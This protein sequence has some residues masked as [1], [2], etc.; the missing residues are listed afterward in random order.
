[1]ALLWAATCYAQPLDR[2]DVVEALLK[3]SRCL[4]DVHFSVPQRLYRQYLRALSDPPEDRPPPVDTIGSRGIYRLSVSADG[5]VTLAVEVRLLVLAPSGRRSVPVL[6]AS[7]AWSD[8]RLAAVGKEPIPAALATI[9]G[10]LCHTPRTPG[11]HVI[12]ARTML[13]R[14]TRRS[15]SV[16]L[17]IIPTVRTEVVFDSQQVFHVTANSGPTALRGRSPKGTHGSLVLPPAGRLDIRFAPLV[18]RPERPARYQLRGQVAWN[19]GA[20]AQQVA[21]DLEIAILG[22]NTDRLEIVLPAAARRVRITGGDV[23]QV[24]VRHGAAVVFLR[25]SVGGRTRLKVSY[26]HELPAAGAAAA[27]A[28]PEIRGGHWAA[29]TLAVTNTVGG[30]ELL[31]RRLAGLK[32][33]AL[34]DIPRSLSAMLAGKAVLAYRITS[35]R[36]SMQLEV[37]DLGAFALRQ[38]IADTAHYRFV[39]RRHGTVLCRADY[40]VRNRNR[41]FLRL[42]LPPGATVL[43][44]RV[45]EKSRP[46]TALAGQPDTYLLPLERSTASVEGLVSFPVQVVY[47][48]RCD[49][50]GPAGSSQVGLPR[51]DVPIAYAWCEAQMP[52][53]IGPLQFAGVMQP[54]EQYSSETAIETMGYGRAVAAGPEAPPARPRSPR[55]RL[56]GLL[57]GRRAQPLPVTQPAAAPAPQLNR[58]MLARNYWRAG[59]DFYDKMQYE[60]ADKAL[61]NVIRLAPKSTEAANAKRLASNI[62]FLQGKLRPEGQAAR[63]AGAKVRQTVT[64]ANIDDL[65]RQ[66]RLLEE[67]LRAARKG[68]RRRAQEQLKAAEAL[69]DQLIARGISKK[70]QSARLREARGKLA[71]ARTKALAEAAAH[72]KRLKEL[73]KAGRHEEASAEAVKLLEAAGGGTGD[74]DADA[75]GAVKKELEELAVAAAIRKADRSRPSAALDTKTPSAGFSGKPPQ[76]KTITRVYDIRDLIVRVPTFT[77][78]GGRRMGDG[79]EDQ[80]ARK[81]IINRLTRQVRS[82]LVGTGRGGIVRVRQANG[83][84]VVEAPA[85]AQHGVK[86][87]VA[88]LRRARGPQVQK[89]AALA[90]Q[91]AKPSWGILDVRYSRIPWHQP[92]RYPRTWSEVTNGRK[93]ADDKALDFLGVGVKD[94]PQLSDKLRNFLAS[95]YSWQRSGGRSHDQRWLAEQLRLNREQKVSVASINVNADAAAAGALGIS[96]RIGNNRV[97]YAVIDE[98]QFRTLMELDR[99]RRR[100]RVAA[101]ERSQETIV[102][103]DA[104]LAN[105]AV[106]NVRYAADR[107]NILD[108]NDNPIRLSH[109]K[110]ILIDNDGYLT[111]VRAEQMQH[112]REAP[113]PV[114]FVQAPQ[115]IEI[116][117]VGQ[118]VKLEKTLVKPDDELAVRFTYRWKGSAE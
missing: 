103:T 50:L 64:A 90:L 12:S 89:G 74:F 22:R 58:I 21:A 54:V 81:K 100:G 118:L 108:I 68:E 107:G 99:R 80:K 113:A 62:G 78:G 60:Q 23:R 17:P 104:L 20:A 32:E 91:Q 86:E 92:L 3:R 16:E 6:P 13:K 55:P 59:R 63:A 29:G 40:E 114:R 56:I 65:E 42:T 87:L 48:Y 72:L 115:T 93:V 66:Q 9:N 70:E 7:L 24:Q 45:N 69:G 26:E 61:Q 35:R 49:P 85:A 38:T 51:I 4:A 109:E 47:I 76:P 46:L 52:L 10:W 31:A 27:L 28:P 67:G 25:G 2:Q 37:V 82:V 110:Y 112:W 41:Q 111:A 94:T 19:L 34:A 33:I 11:R 79:T 75:A 101:N 84:I 106:S 36:W 8:I 39:Y 71:R 105:A 96:F 83:Q 98:A 44:A 53:D 117:H 88:G 73:R 1:L 15:G 102:G 18:V 95:N 30:S 5:Q 77:G 57:Q 43:L 116:P 97:R 14:L